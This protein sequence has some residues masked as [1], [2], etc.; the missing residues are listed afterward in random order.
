MMVYN[1]TFYNSYSNHNLSQKRVILAGKMRFILIS[2]S[3]ASFELRNFAK[4]KFLYTTEPLCHHNWILYLN[5]SSEYRELCSRER[6][7]D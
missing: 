2:L 1:N 4:I 6:H 3:Y 7:T 5:R